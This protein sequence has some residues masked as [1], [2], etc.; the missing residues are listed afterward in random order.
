M[1]AHPQAGAWAASS[2]AAVRSLDRLLGLATEPLAAV[3]VVAEVLVLLTGVVSRFIFN[4][5]LT[6]SDE[7]GSSFGDSPALVPRR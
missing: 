2:P 5:P 7:S 1:S 4:H 6:W 3:V